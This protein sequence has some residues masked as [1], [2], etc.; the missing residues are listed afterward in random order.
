MLARHGFTQETWHK[1]STRVMSAHRA[2]LAA[3]PREDDV[4]RK[5]NQDRS[6][7]A[8]QR[9][10]LRAMMAEQSRDMA[11]VAADT[12]Q[13]QAVVAPFRERLEQILIR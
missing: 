4:S 11:A 9:H 5:L 12:R 8:E 13:D 7:S 2:M 6:L 10:A 1:V 3:V